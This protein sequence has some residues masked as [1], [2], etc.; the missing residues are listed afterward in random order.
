MP[1]RI[2]LPVPSL[3]RSQGGPEGQSLRVVEYTLPSSV[4]LATLDNWLHQ[5][6]GP[7]CSNIS[8][9]L[10]TFTRARMHVPRMVTTG[11]MTW[12]SLRGA[13]M[14]DVITGTTGNQ[15]TIAITEASL[16]SSLGT[17]PCR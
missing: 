2:S 14:L 17:V 1:G 16:P 9:G 5:H 8:T 3:A 6:L 4:R 15:P 13:T 12:T 7:S 11:G 10:L